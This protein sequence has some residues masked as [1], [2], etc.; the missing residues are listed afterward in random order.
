MKNKY[1]RNR[2][3]RIKYWKRVKTEEHPYETSNPYSISG[4]LWRTEEEQVKRNFEDIAKKARAMENGTH[5]QWLVWNASSEYR[6]LL[7]RKVKARERA[8]MQKL[9][10]GNE[11]VEFPK[12]LKDAT[13]HYF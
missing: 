7:N 9:L 3:F 11:E 12:H 5:K 2:A 1:N 8:A 4:H 10:K 6:R 13:W